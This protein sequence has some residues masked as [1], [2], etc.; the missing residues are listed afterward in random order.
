[1]H[2]RQRLAVDTGVGDEDTLRDERLV[3]LLEVNVQLGT[4]KGHDSLL[5]SF[6]TD[7]QHL[8]AQ[9]ENSI[10][11]R[12]AQLALVNQT[13]HHEVA[14]QEVVNLQQRLAL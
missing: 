13:R 11:V 5:V 8:V 7:N 12:N 14:V 9:V 1:M 10:A 2:G 6:G 4:D 3:L